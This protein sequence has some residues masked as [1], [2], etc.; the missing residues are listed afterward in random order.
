MAHLAGLRSSRQFVLYFA[1]GK[2]VLRKL[3]EAGGLK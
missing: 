1:I 2:A 3:I